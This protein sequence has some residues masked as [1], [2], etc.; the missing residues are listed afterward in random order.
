VN[1]RREFLRVGGSGVPGR[2]LPQRLARRLIEAGTRVVTIYQQLGLDHR[3]ELYDSLERPHALV[4]KA[5]VIDEL[6]V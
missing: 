2:S 6:L 3:T 4:P 1:T 5:R